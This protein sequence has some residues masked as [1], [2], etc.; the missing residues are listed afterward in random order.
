MRAQKMLTGG[1]GD[2]DRPGL[3][4][5]RTDRAG[6]GP[7]LGAVGARDHARQL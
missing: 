6:S 5:H 2:T 7:N 3:A 4:G 1:G